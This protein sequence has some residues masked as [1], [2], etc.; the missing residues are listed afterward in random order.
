M[1]N[2]E[3][4]TEIIEIDIN[5]SLVFKIFQN[6]F[7]IIF[8]DPPYKEKKLFEMLENIF[9]YNLLKNNGVI[10]IHRHKKEFDKFPLKFEIIEEKS[11]GISKVIFGNYV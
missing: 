1:L 7:D 5:N 3:E 6:Q 4:N 10:I 9:E 11:Y 8:L 2:Y